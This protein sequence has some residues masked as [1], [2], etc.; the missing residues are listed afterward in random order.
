VRELI[1]ALSLAVLWLPIASLAQLSPPNKMG[2]TM[3]H[4]HYI[5]RDVEAN[6]KFWVALGA[7]PLTRGSREA[8]MLPGLM[9]FLDQGNTSGGTE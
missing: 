6:K 4:L 2:V 3:G 1:L 8:L 7:T 5:V 9:I